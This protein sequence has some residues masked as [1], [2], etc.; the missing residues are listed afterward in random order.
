MNKRKDTRGRNLKHGEIQQSDG[1]YK[2]Q[3]TDAHGMRKAVYSWRL[4][5]TDRLPP[6]KRDDLSL[7]EKK[8]RSRGIDRTA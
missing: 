1:R 6:G 5:P 8:N 3:W 2:Y 7:R 4:V